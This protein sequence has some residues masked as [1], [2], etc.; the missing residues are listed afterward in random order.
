MCAAIED[1]TFITEEIDQDGGKGAI[2]LLTGMEPRELG[3]GNFV[4]PGTVVVMVLALDRSV[5]H[6]IYGASL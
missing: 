4:V 5:C 3:V 1:G 6:N 2:L